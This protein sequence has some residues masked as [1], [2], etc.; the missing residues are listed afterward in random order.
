MIYVFFYVFLHRFIFKRLP[1]A[2]SFILLLLFYFTSNLTLN[3]IFW[4]LLSDFD[5]THMTLPLWL[6]GILA[7]SLPSMFTYA[8]IIPLIFIPFAVYEKLGWGDVV[9]FVILALH[10]PKTITSILMV[11]SLTSLIFSLV[12]QKKKTPFVPF[13]V[14]GIYLVHAFHL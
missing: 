8:L 1:R 13:I 12:F 2:M 14:F 7:C 11:A 4:L 9:C 3:I 10:F 5:L 6:L